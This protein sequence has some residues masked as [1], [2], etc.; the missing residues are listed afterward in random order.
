MSTFKTQKARSSES[1]DNGRRTFFWKLGVGASTALA[2][3]AGIASVRA[4][5]ADDAALRLALLEDEKALRELHQTYEQALD[6]GAYHEVV[7]MFADDAEVVFNGEVFR[8]RSRGLSRLYRERFAAG[9]IGKRMEPAPGFELSA[10]QLRD[11]VNV[12]P[13]RLNAKAVFPYSIRVG[14]PIETE[15]SLASMAR[16]HGEGV[17]SW[18]EGGLYEV[19]Y[20]KDAPD[21]RWKIKSLAYR[22][23][24]RADYRAGRTYARPLPV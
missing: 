12:A 4:D 19:S 7:G 14:M 21:G 15:T 5:A 11:S 6:A 18:W 22:T 16:V 2:S 1:V 8:A 3:T 23:L 10:E 20:T 9:K 17:R 13:D 24:A